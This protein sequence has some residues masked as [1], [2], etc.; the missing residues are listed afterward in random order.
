MASNRI[1]PVLHHVRKLAL[2]GDMATWTDGQLLQRYLADRDEGAFA[3]LVQRHGPMVLGVCRR[4][5]HDPH[6]ADDAFQAT[7]L[8][9]VR[10]ASSIVPRDMVA[11]WLYGV[12]FQTAVRA[13][14]MRAR[15]QQREKQVSDMPEPTSLPCDPADDLRRLL[16]QE[17]ARLSDK[18]RAA[19]VLCDLEGKTRKEA[20]AQLGWPEGTVSSRLSRARALL[21][22]RLARHGLPVSAGTLAGLL[23]QEAPAAAL[24]TATTRA[25]SLLAVGQAALISAHVITLTEG[26]LK[27]MFLIKLKTLASLVLALGV[28]AAT[29]AILALGP[30]AEVNEPATKATPVAIGALDERG[31]AQKSDQSDLARLQGTWM[32]ARLEY[33]GVDM[34][35]RS[36]NGLFRLVIKGERLY[37]VFGGG[38]PED[39]I[40]DFKFKLY[41]GKQPKAIDISPVKGPAQTLP[42]IY[43]LVG[44]HLTICYCKDGK[45]E[46][47]RALVDYWQGGSHML[48]LVLQRLPEEEKK[49]APAKAERNDLLKEQRERLLVEEQRATQ[50]VEDGLRQALQRVRDN[51]D[52]TDATRKALEARL[53]AALRPQT[54]PAQTESDRIRPG[55]RLQIEVHET[56]PNWPIKGVVRVEPQGTVALGGPYGRVQVKG[57]TFEEAEKTIQRYLAD[58]VK[59]PM[60][61][62]TGY[63][64]LLHESSGLE[65]RVQELEKELRA[66]RATLEALQKKKVP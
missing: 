10:K 35:A 24:I 5:L 17:L 44:D 53:H 26:V 23:T 21:A 42:G 58:I 48:L 36:T 33:N 63:D 29:S 55:D 46:R 59:N 66:M 16:D 31:A 28:V 18:Y 57:L 25:S 4:L 9:L 39:L 12:A 62:V 50:Q 1:H 37:T 60:V 6:D 7:F 45:L 47:P 52:L 22:R 14:S 65:R 32:P 3:A 15:Q 8:V 54:E 51:P 2:R 11:N 27:T 49:S 56:L 38:R 64:P 40:S 61:A 19:V 34:T 30:G 20:A 43:R 13:R 41:P